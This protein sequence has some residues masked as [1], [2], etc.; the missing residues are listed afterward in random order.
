M[1]CAVCNHE[2]REGAA[3]CLH[4]GEASWVSGIAPFTAESCPDLDLVTDP[5]DTPK[6]PAED[7]PLPHI[8]THADI[9]IAF[10]SEP[11]TSVDAPVSK[12][13]AKR[14]A[15]GDIV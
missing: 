4:C 14:A 10:P 11:V 3:T 13:A 2:A 12:R 6:P 1:L 8:S 7:V 9:P 15:R 5:P